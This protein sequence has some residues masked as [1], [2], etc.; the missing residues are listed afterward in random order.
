M[1]LPR[2]FGEI[3]FLQSSLFLYVTGLPL[4]YWSEFYWSV[5]LGGGF[6]FGVF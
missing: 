2:D 4:C 5:L 3:L 6:Q 1:H